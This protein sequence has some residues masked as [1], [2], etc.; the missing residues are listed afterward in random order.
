M[1][2]AV[3]QQLD[4]L[5]SASDELRGNRAAVLEALKQNGMA[6]QYASMEI[7][8]CGG[9]RSS[10]ARSWAFATRHSILTARGAVAVEPYFG[11]WRA[12]LPQV[13][14]GAPLVIS[15]YTSTERSPWLGVIDALTASSQIV[16][17][18][19]ARSAARAKTAHGASTPR[20]RPSPQLSREAPGLPL[21]MSRNSQGT[22][23]T[24]A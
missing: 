17:R 12:L 11:P 6:S 15:T 19:S 18:S 21:R 7:A 4:V 13:N 10:G 20:T 9:P 14:A 3:K 8:G 22:S 2:G 16:F 5:A 24:S 23:F 1:L